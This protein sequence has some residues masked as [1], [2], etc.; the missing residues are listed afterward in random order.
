MQQYI[1]INM[2][3][4]IYQIVIRQINKWFINIIIVCKRNNMYVHVE[5]THSTDKNWIY[6]L[7]KWEIILLEFLLQ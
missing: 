4:Y 5:V 1:C 7:Q 3:M 2:Y 6:I